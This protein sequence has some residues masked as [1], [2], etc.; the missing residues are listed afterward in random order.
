M[1]NCEKNVIAFVSFSC[2]CNETDPCARNVGVLCHNRSPG[3]WCPP[4]PNGYAGKEIHGIGL[5][6]AKNN[7]QV[8]Q[9]SIFESVSNRISTAPKFVL[10]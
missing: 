7:K 9:T 4:C 2:K 6:F 3:Y 1:N 8:K 5:Y 10:I